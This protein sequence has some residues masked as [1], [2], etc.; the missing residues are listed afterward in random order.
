MCSYEYGDERVNV[1]EVEI[2]D[3][4]CW[5]Y[6]FLHFKSER[7]DVVLHRMKRFYNIPIECSDRVKAI[8]VSGKLDMK[9]DIQEVL[10]N[11]ALTAPVRYTQKRNK[12]IMDVQPLKQ[13]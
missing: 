4:I 1:S 5:K 10:K 3:H 8:R 6:G 11:I 13:F 2:Y 12:I 9:E 7:L